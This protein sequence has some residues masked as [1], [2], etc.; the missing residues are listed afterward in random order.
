VEAAEIDVGALLAEVQLE[1][2]ESPRFDID[3]GD[4]LAH[5]KEHGYCILSGVADAESVEHARNL[6]WDF[7]ENVPD[8]QAKRED[9]STWEDRWIPSSTNG[10]IGV[11]GFGQSNFCWHARTLPKVRQ[12]F[13]T[14]WDCKD[15][16]VS[17]DGG[18]AFRPWANKPDWKTAG[19]WWHVDQNAFLANQDGFRCIQGL[20]TFTDATA[21]TGGL[22]VVPGSHKHHKDLCSR[23]YAHM[24]PK[25]FVQVQPGDPLLQS[26]AR[27]VCAKA[28]D[29]ILWDSR[30]I[31]CNTPGSCEAMNDS[32]I[33]EKVSDDE[34]LRIVAYVCMTPSSWASPEVLA[35]RKEAFLKNETL[36]HIPHEYHGS[37]SSSLS[38]PPRKTW[39]DVSFLQRRLICGAP[40]ALEDV[41]QKR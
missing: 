20:V 8:A 35:Q 4:W 41:V 9:P 1:T 32:V 28:G 14:I 3:D 25:H 16:I 2:Q 15:L 33:S 12:A 18:N 37:E 22:C 5:L 7:L 36:D 26:R 34:L 19:G 27:L 30:C 24:S 31:H 21:A 23:A 38:W 29:L 6:I 13:E 10:L 11:H 40:A 17:F 39:S